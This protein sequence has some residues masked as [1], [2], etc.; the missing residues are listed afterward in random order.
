MQKPIEYKKGQKIN[1]FVYL[2][3]LEKINNRRA[4]VRCHCGKEFPVFIG[5]IVRKT[6][7]SCGCYRRENA[8][9]MFF[10]HGDSGKDIYLYR[11]WMSIKRRCY[12]KNNKDYRWYGMRGI[13][14]CDEW[15]N[16]YPKFKQWI[17]LNIGS[18]PKGLTLDRINNDGNYEPFN[19][20]WATPKQQANNRSNNKIL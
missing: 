14:I 12:N 13:I 5:N 10:K 19:L 18:R 11:L 4:L 7:T 17:L 15:C 1:G 9:M 3:E 20:R 16:D 6:T 8:S 2:R